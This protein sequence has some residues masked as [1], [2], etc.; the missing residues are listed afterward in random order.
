MIQLLQAARINTANARS[1]LCF[2]ESGKEAE[3]KRQQQTLQSQQ[4]H[5]WYKIRQATHTSNFLLLSRRDWL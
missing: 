5:I 4:Q 2:P 1:A 3:K